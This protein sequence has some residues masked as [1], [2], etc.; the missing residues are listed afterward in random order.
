MSFGQIVTIVFVIFI[1]YLTFGDKIEKLYEAQ[2][3]LTFELCD[4]PYTTKFFNNMEKT[5][6]ESLLKEIGALCASKH[7]TDKL[8]CTDTGYWLANNLTD[9]GVDN[10]LIIELIPICTEACEIQK[11][12]LGNI[13]TKKEVKKKKK[14]TGQIEQTK[15]IWDD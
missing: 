8:S 11:T 15:W 12:P 14:P 2:K 3:D 10:D 6:Q 1:G 13:N 4:V 5:E 9:E 7:H